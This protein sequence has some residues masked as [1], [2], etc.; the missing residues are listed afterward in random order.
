MSKFVTEIF[1]G[2]VA[3]M[4]A[5]DAIARHMERRDNRNMRNE[6][7]EMLERSKAFLRIEQ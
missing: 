6:M 1:P 3:L 5:W 7:R 2:L 4:L